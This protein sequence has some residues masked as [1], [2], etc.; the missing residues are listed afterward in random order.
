MMLKKIGADIVQTHNWGTALEGILGAKLARIQGIVH[1][2]RGTIED[3]AHNIVLQRFLWGF[4]DQ[5]LS[6]SDAHRKKMRNIIGFPHEQIKSIVNGVDTERFFPNPEIKEKIRKKLGLKKSS[7]CI[8]TIG[9][10]RFVKNQSLLVNACKTILPSFDQVEVLIVGE[11]PLESQLIQEVK[12]LGFSE[13]IHFAGAQPNIPAI[14]N[15]LDIFVLPSQA[16]GISNTILE[17]MATGLPVI[18]TEVGGNTELIKAGETGLLVP[19]SNPEL[20]AKAILAL[21]INKQ[22]RLELGKNAHQSILDNFTIQ[23]MVNNYT[24]V[25]DSVLVKGKL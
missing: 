14:L 23:V 6:V 11:G 8:G 18:A 5:V 16:E 3:K 10:L 25:Y 7:V 12:T 17:A 9:S 21:V 19:P 1:A 22:K 20:L 4:A 24:A 2:E 15:A 13:K